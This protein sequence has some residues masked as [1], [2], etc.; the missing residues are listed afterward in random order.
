MTALRDSSGILLGFAKIFS[1]ETEN[2]KLQDSLTESNS[3]LEQ[4]AYIASHDLQEPLRTIS[5]FAEVLSRK[6]GHSWMRKG[7]TSSA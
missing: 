4:F 2:K 6:Y 5:S 3:A 7:S 1:D